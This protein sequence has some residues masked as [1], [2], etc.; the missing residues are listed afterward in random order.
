MVMGGLVRQVIDISGGVKAMLTRGT[1]APAESFALLVIWQGKDE[2]GDGLHPVLQ[3]GPYR[4][5]AEAK[6]KAEADLVWLEDA[7]A[8]GVGLKPEGA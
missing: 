7:L 6:R 5:E 3:V 1:T 8:A 2:S 4:D